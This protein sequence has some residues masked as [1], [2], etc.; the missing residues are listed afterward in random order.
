MN[1]SYCIRTKHGHD[2][3]ALTSS[4]DLI[5][6]NLGRYEELGRTQSAGRSR[7]KVTIV[8]SCLSYM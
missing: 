2:P 3:G 5:F 7:P 8:T 1:V 4:L 6:L